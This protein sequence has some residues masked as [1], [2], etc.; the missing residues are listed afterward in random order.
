[1]PVQPIQALFFRDWNNSHIP[2]IMEEIWIKKI[3]EP[4]LTGRTDLVIADLGSNIGLTL[5]YFKD[6]AKQIYA[7]EPTKDHLEILTKDIEF[8]KFTNIKICPYAISNTNGKATLNHSPNSTANSL[9]LKVDPKNNEEVEVLDIEKF[10]EREKIEYIDIL[11]LDVEGSESKVIASD[12]FKRVCP[13]IKVIFGEYHPWT[14]M[15]PELFA[16]SLE[17]LG[18]IFHWNRNT[19]AATFTAVYMPEIEKKPGI[20]LPPNL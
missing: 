15:K 5:L 14:S 18:Y 19:I 9:E 7:V 16:H 20:I 4:F 8:N 6:F 10:M 13:K 17:E 3:Y 11:K 12:A 1:M 2:E